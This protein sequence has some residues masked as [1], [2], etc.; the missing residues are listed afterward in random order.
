MT[1]KRK[2][3]SGSTPA[4]NKEMRPL[5]YKCC[6]CGTRMGLHLIEGPAFACDKCDTVSD[7]NARA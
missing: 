7:K 4:T 6:K 5:V 2:R 1:T 3:P